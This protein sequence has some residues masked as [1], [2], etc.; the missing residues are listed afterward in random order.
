MSIIKGIS[1]KIRGKR[2][3]HKDKTQLNSLSEATV[4][5]ALK[6]VVDPDLHKDIVSLGFVKKVEINGSI[7]NVTVQLTTPACPV[8]EELKKQ[9]E[10]SIL[11]IRGV[12][13]VNV[14][15]TFPSSSRPAQAAEKKNNGLVQVKNI[16]A[17]ASG[18]GGV[19]KS[20]TAMNLARSL[21]RTS[22][23]VGVIDAD[24]YGPSIPTL[25]QAGKPTQMDG[26]LVIPPEVDGIK[27]IS[28]SMF[29]QGDKAHILRGPMAANLVKQFLSGVAWGELDY[30][31]IDYPPG[32]GDIQLTIS[33]IASL[34][35][36][37]IVTTPQELALADVKKAISMFTTMKVPIIGIIEN[38]SYFICDGCE[39]KHYI[40]KTGGGKKLAKNSGLPLLGE[41]P[42]EPYIVKA[43]DE[44]LDFDSEGSKLPE[45]Y[46]QVTDRV[47]RELAILNSNQGLGLNSFSLAWK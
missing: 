12:N 42:I 34:A 9:C 39:K 23:K 26:E 41:I 8:K 43:S 30:L 22:A 32:T 13:E 14:T 31:L 16:I 17:V 47:V 18:K 11:K 25:S 37:V 3:G 5:E 21:A 27:L 40:F 29:S 33:Q 45:S 36:A 2:Q 28:V 10:D 6:S 44:G 38:M 7:V 4:Y 1:D 24:I 20:T 15:L 19:G 35:G 46:K